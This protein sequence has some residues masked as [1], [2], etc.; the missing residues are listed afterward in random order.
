MVCVGGSGYYLWQT[1]YFK[2]GLANVEAVNYTNSESGFNSE[3]STIINNDKFGFNFR[4]PRSWKQ[5]QNESD[6][7][8]YT[9]YPDYGLSLVELMVIE[10]PNWEIF[11]TEPLARKEFFIGNYLVNNFFSFKGLESK[12][13][14]G[15]AAK[16]NSEVQIIQLRGGTLAFVFTAV[17]PSDMT[18]NEFLAEFNRLVQSL[19]LVD[20]R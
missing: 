4:Y 1:N 13:F 8:L 16:E 12:K 19:N 10:N 6:D 11:N 2:K 17:Y 18:N 5:A 7:S 15:R 14:K 3:N 20:K 9:F